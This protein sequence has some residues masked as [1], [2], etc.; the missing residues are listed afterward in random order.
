MDKQ[1]AFDIVYKGVLS[2]GGRSMGYFIGDKKELGCMYRGE[3]GRKC[4]IGWL[5]PDDKY[6]VKFDSETEYPANPMLVLKEV[7]IELPYDFVDELQDAH[8]DCEARGTP[9][10]IGFITTMTALAGRHGLNVPEISLQD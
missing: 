7:G 1:E 6:D 2:Q 4:A 9:F 10:R 8:D 3:K 5:I